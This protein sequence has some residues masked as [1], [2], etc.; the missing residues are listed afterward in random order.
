MK[1]SGVVGIGRIRFKGGNMKLHMGLIL[2]TLLAI[3]LSGCGDDANAS[4]EAP[5]ANV[6]H[7]CKLIQSEAVWRVGTLCQKGELSQG[8]GVNPQGQMVSGCVTVKLV[9]GER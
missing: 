7:T 5:V 1:V 8:H 4:S 3:A 2:Y 6:T 9:C